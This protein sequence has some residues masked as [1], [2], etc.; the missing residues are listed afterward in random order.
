MTVTAS[1]VMAIRPVLRQTPYG[2]LAV[3]EPG[4]PLPICVVAGTEEDARASFNQSLKAWA[5]LRALP[6]PAWVEGQVSA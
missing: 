4:A 3:S 6:D 1:H 2:W 5:R